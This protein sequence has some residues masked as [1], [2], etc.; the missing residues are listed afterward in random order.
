MMIDFA[1]MSWVVNYEVFTFLFTSQ[2]NSTNIR[3]VKGNWE[4]VYLQ[5]VFIYLSETLDKFF[6][7]LFLSFLSVFEKSLGYQRE[8]GVVFFVV[9]EKSNF[10]ICLVQNTYSYLFIYFVCF[11]SALELEEGTGENF[12]CFILL[13]FRINNF[14]LF[15]NHR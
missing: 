9:E 2:V 7:E 3:I 10:D 8:I 15:E 11:L 5:D 14:F 4:D 13:I 1:S 12:L 6:F